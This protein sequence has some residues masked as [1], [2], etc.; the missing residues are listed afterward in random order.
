MSN[1]V[2]FV[3]TYRAEFNRAEFFAEGFQTAH[4]GASAEVEDTTANPI[5]HSTWQV[6]IDRQP[7]PGAQTR[8]QFDWTPAPWY[9][10]K[11]PWYEKA[12]NNKLIVIR[13]RVTKFK[14]AGTICFNNKLIA[15]RLRGSKLKHPG[16]KR[17]RG[18]WGG[19]RVGLER[20]RRSCLVANRATLPPKWPPPP[21]EHGRFV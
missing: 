4:D 6:V 9:N 2:V 13:A 10:V 17:A 12:L 5:C 15:T 3:C 7:I 20:C 11:T 18:W 19:R 21:S 16:A 8:Q 1:G 14:H